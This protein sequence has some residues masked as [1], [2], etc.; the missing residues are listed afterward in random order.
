MAAVR[1][2]EIA[3]KPNT[4]DLHVEGERVVGAVYLET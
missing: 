1:S 3:S 4:V 2:L